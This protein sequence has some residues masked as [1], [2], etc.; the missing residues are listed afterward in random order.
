M[1]LIFLH[2]DIFCCIEKN[3][4]AMPLQATVGGIPGKGGREG[5]AGEQT[6]IVLNFV[7][8]G[9]RHIVVHT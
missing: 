2:W 4:F 8:S 6:V 7:S 5:G 3:I 1:G 9:F